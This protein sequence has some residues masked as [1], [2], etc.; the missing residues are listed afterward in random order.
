MNYVKK[1]VTQGTI[2]TQSGEYLLRNNTYMQLFQDIAQGDEII[3]TIFSFIIIGADFNEREE[4]EKR[5]MV[6]SRVGR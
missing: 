6:G 4:R 3:N 1:T 5:K 2:R